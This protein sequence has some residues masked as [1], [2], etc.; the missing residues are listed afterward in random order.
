MA[1]TL[2][3]LAAV[4]TIERLRFLTLDA[5]QKDSRVPGELERLV[6][7]W[8][9]A[10]GRGNVR[11]VLEGLRGDGSDSGF[12]FVTR[13]DLEALGYRPEPRQ[14]EVPTPAGRRRIDI[15]FLPHMIGI[16]CLGFAYH[17]S[18]EAF[19]SDALRS[20]DLAEADEWLILRLTWQM[21]LRHW[22]RF[23]ASFARAYRRR[24]EQL[25]AR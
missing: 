12:E 8:P 25:R 23:V 13:R 2:F 17:G 1:R 22:D 10:R 7:Q 20:N 9:T 24:E 4:T 18:R 11:V 6:G 16:E 5:R 19:E 3:D 14:V 21:R 15:P